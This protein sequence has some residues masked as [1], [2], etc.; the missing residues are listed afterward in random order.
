M[1]A[2]PRRRSV[3]AAALA[4]AVVLSCLATAIDAT[5][6]AYVSST[7]NGASHFATAATF[8]SSCT[9]VTTFAGGLG[10]GAAATS[11]RMSPRAVAVDG[12]SAVAVADSDS[13]AARSIDTASRDAVV[14]AGTGAAGARGDGGPGTSAE[15]SSPFG[16]AIDAD[17]T[18][19]VADRANNKVRKIT[20]AGT[21]STFAG[22]GTAGSGGDGGAATAA[23]LNLPR[24]V[25][26]HGGSVYIAETGG[27]R[28]RKV[29]ADG[30]ISTVAGTGTAGAGGDGGPATSAQLSS[31]QAVAVAADGTLYVADTGN[32]KVRRIGT[33][34]TISTFA[35]TGTAGAG[36]DGAAA[37]A[38]TLSGPT[39]V[40]VDAAGNV[41]IGDTANNK[42]RRVATSGTISTF[43]GTGTAGGAGDG[44]AAT[45]AQLSAPRGVA[46]DS[47]GV[48][49]IA[50]YGNFK[51]RRV[52]A[53]GTISTFGGT[54]V[55]GS[56]L[57]TVGDGGAAT[58]A[59]L[60]QPWNV[61]VDSA[62]NVY[63]ADTENHK[64]RKV[65]PSGTISTLAGTG[66]AGSTG[67]GGPATSAQLD[68]PQ[69]V[70]VDA[71]GNVFIADSRSNKVRKVTPA[72]T[73]STYAGTGAAGATGDGGPATAA[74]LDYPRTVTVDAAG[75]LYIADNANHTIRKVT[76]SGTISTFAG[77]GQSGSTGDGGPATAAKINN[78]YGIA[79]DASGNVFLANWGENKVRKVNPSG[80]IS[81]VAGIGGTP[82]YGGDGGPATAANLSYPHGIAVAA[83]GSF[84][85]ADNGSHRV[86]R[87]STAGTISTFMGDGTPAFGGDCGPAAG[88]QVAY[89][90]GLA[91]HDGA[92]LVADSFNG[93]IRRVP[94]P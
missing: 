20:S 21:I 33:G 6:S 55:Q 42:V 66:T 80:I 29:A 63:V 59:Q 85:I 58:S 92:L 93:R 44:A 38:A 56:A 8:T 48:V 67:D 13:N 4:A 37:T 18:T 75:V 15:L 36:G 69:G 46:V 91:I 5:F 68:T 61:T 25:A 84:Y 32:N 23:T 24:G 51:V 88:A 3:P 30:T 70:A 73:I 52:S 72:G 34:G 43:A 53:S 9:G 28:I 47:A 74:K 81:T 14:T 10:S 60:N 94:L 19:Y 86:R 27:H 1:G 50:D 54:G 49:Y 82:A 57:G 26:V 62:G 2:R 65:T 45:A 22:T 35:G 78:P 83:D 79:I 39:G 40:A 31:P 7:A 41:L 64:I 12:T 87:V 89:P 77:T 17:G 76:T 16:I 90:A 11:I 71:D